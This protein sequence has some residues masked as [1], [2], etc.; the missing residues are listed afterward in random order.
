VALINSFRVCISSL[1]RWR[2]VSTNRKIF[3]AAL[4]IALLTLGGKLVS[5]AKEVVVAASFGTGNAID[6]FLIALVVPSFAINVIGGSFNAA[7]IPTFIRVREK[8]GMDSA[9]RLFSSVMVW[10]TGLLAGATVIIVLAAPFYLPLIASGF[11]AE[12]IDLTRQLLYML[13]PIVMICGVTTIWGAVLNAGER[14]ALVAVTPALTPA[15]IIFF[16][17]LVGRT[18]G[19]TALTL[20]TVCGMAMEGAILGIG[21]RRKGISVKPRWHGMDAHVKQVAGQY[22]PMISGA[23]ILSSTSLINQGM[24]ATL[25]SGSV[26]ALNYGNKLIAVPIGIATTALGTAVIPYFSTMVARNDWAGIRH[27]L[28][29]FFGL[30]FGTSVPFVVAFILISEPLIRLLF[31]RGSFTAEDTHLIARIQV[32]FALQ[33]P[34]YVAAIMV[35]RLISAMLANHILMIGNIISLLLSVSLNYLFMKK[36]GVA[37]IAL[38]TSC[39]YMVSFL[40]LYFSWYLIWKVHQ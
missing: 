31:Q 36:L 22:M 32:L 27:T 20:G 10:S 24:A 23:L 2:D 29:R 1:N 6:A 18:W 33:I 3:G 11:S 28:K 34:F 15:F 40:F 19:I 9:Q 26:A 12:K 5:M 38:S 37:G 30:I 8:E 7:L 39:V 21:L 16:L 13:S 4:V 35:V 17:M 25:T 14:F